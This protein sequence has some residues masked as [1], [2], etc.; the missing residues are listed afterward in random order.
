MHR[1]PRFIV[2]G[3]KAGED[4]P[5]R[6]PGPVAAAYWL[7]HC[8]GFRVDG[9]NGRI[10][11]V[12]HVEQ[13]GEA[14]VPDIMAVASGLWRIRLSRIPLAD[15]VQVDPGRRRVVVRHDIAEP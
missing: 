9:P 5:S 11:V 15:V 8:D 10:G 1:L 4:G 13:G 12:D 2:R 14:D 3:S 7:R 6:S